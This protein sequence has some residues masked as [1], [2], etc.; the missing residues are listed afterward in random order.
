MLILLDTEMCQ[1]YVI[2][3]VQFLCRVITHAVSA[4]NTPTTMPT[5]CNK[6]PSLVMKIAG[7]LNVDV[8]L[9]T[10][11][12]VTELYSSGFDRLAQEVCKGICSAVTRGG[13]YN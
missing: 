5:V 3:I 6:W 2:L 4:A 7:P 10:R 1:M 13:M 12:H 11:H 9:L 8:D